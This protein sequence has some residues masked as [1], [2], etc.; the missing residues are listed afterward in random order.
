MSL[1]LSL[2][3][4][5]TVYVAYKVESIKRYNICQS[6]AQYLAHSENTAD[7]PVPLFLGKQALLHRIKPLF[8]P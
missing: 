7:V 3:M 8:R 1:Y 5:A 2:H 6:P 4:C